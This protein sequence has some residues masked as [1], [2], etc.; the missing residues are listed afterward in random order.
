MNKKAVSP[1]FVRATPRTGKRLYFYLDGE[2]M[3][4]F[5]GETVL[6]AILCNTDHVRRFEFTDSFRAGF[7]LMAVCQDCWV[8]C[9]NGARLRACTTQLEDGMRLL[10]VTTLQEIGAP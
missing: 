4:G 9:E 6:T 1:R 2:P 3:S 5:L 8:W 7:C 10:S